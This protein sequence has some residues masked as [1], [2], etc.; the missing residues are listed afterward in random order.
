[1]DRDIA[2]K[3]RTSFTNIKTTLTSMA[4]G[5]G[6]TPA[7]AVNLSRENMFSPDVI[8]D[9]VEDTRSAEAPE[10]NPE[11]NPEEEPV[12]KSTRKK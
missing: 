3:I 5:S 9:P 2:L 4:T 12:T 8:S 1:M 7:T 11:E 6:E 10:E